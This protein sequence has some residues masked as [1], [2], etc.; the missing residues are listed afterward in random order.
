MINYSNYLLSMKRIIY[1]CFSIAWPISI[2]SA[3][4]K[5]SEYDVQNLIRCYHIERDSGTYATKRAYFDAFPTTF[6]DFK[7][8]FDYEEVLKDET[9]GPLYEESFE[10]I[11]AFFNLYKD[12]NLF[13]FSNKAIRMCIDGEWDADAVNYLHSNIVNIITSSNHGQDCYYNYFDILT[14]YNDTVKDTFLSCLT[15]LS[16]DEILSFWRF[17]LDGVEIIPIDED[18]FKRTKN[19]IQKNPN[20]VRQFEKAYNQISQKRHTI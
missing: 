17:Y 2:I 10:Y 6:I 3:Q 14:C 15:L 9:Y 16:D 12:I 19:I 7:N 8:T 20:L 18:L 1:I 4:T 5:T 13:D 11:S